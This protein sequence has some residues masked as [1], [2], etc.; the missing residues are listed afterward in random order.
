M[1]D[2]SNTIENQLPQAPEGDTQAAEAGSSGK[3]QRKLD[4]GFKRNMLIIGGVVVGLFALVLI[5]M[6]MRSA[7]AEKKSSPVSTSMRQT[8]VSNGE[9]EQMSPA[10]KEAVREKQIKEEKKAAEKG[11][12]VFVPRDTLEAPVALAPKTKPVNET[13]P[14]SQQANGQPLINPGDAA[15]NE[16]RRKGLEVQLAQLMNASADMGGASPQRVAFENKLP[17]SSAGTG[18]GSGVGTSATGLIS[19]PPVVE[20]LEIVPA[21]TASPI[22]TYRTKYA[23]AR[24]VAGKLAGAFLVGKSELIDEGV[25]TSYNMMRFNGKTYAIDAIALDEKTSTDAL[26][27]NID[28]RYLQ[29][30]VMPVAMAAIGGAATALSQTGSQVVATAGGA[31]GASPPPTS[32]QARAAGIAAGVSIAARQVDKEAQK[33]LQA[34]LPANTPIGILFRAPVDASAAK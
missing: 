8:T 23:S 11:D 4:P 25:T 27:A 9:N 34:T 14:V 32:D 12:T 33:P 26:A 10:M 2:E 28:H 24:I 1:T 6:M 3:A 20:G 29:R 19:G 15:R 5:M 17:P 13:A 21:E 22:D 31:V 30:Y 16:L 18:N 7:S